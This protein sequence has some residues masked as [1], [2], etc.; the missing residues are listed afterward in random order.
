[1]TKSDQIYN[2]THQIAPFKKNSPGG[3]PLYSPTKEAPGNTSCKRDVGLY[4]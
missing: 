3:M 4:K 2:K 1:M